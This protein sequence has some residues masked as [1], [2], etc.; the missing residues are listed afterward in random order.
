MQEWTRNVYQQRIWNALPI[1]ETGVRVVCVYRAGMFW[2]SF[3]RS[4]HLHSCQKCTQGIFLTQPTASCFHHYSIYLPA[5]PK[6][7]TPQYRLPEPSITW[8]IY[9]TV[10][11]HLYKILW[12]VRAILLQAGGKDSIGHRLGV[13]MVLLRQV[14]LVNT[15][16]LISSSSLLVPQSI[17]FSIILST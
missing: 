3:H 15:C 17:M 10:E 12:C 1:L 13:K 4:D 6:M 16:K 2:S 8:V 7:P 14:T 5:P 9:C 11:L